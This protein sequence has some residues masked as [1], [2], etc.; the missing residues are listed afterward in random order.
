MYLIPSIAITNLKCINLGAK[1]EIY[2]VYLH[3]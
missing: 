1:Y 3:E 2:R